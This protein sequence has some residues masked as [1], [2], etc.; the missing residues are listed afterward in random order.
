MLLLLLIFACDVLIQP[1][2]HWTTRR[3]SSN[4]VNGISIIELWCVQGI[5]VNTQ[6]KRVWKSENC[7]E[8]DFSHF[9]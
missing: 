6:Y 8:S 9:E 2:S 4:Q 5:T 1:A 3:R 7:T